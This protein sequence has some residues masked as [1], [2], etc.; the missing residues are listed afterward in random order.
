[1]SSKR[2]LF[3]N[4]FSNSRWW[5][6]ERPQ[7]RDVQLDSEG[8]FVDVLLNKRIGDP[9]RMDDKRTRN[10][11]VLVN[12]F[13]TRYEQQVWIMENLAEIARRLENKVGRDI[14]INSV[15]TDPGYDTVERL[16]AFAKKLQAPTGWTFVRATGGASQA[17]VGRMG[18]V[19]GYTSTQEIFY[20]TP[21]GFWGTFPAENTPAEVAYRLTNTIPRAKPKRLQRAGPVPLDKV[22]HNWTSRMS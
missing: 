10:K 8:E 16:Q 13:T 4:L 7:I 19:R 20:G 5:L 11:L 22:K 14:F 3:T 21:N 17:L 18:R 15:S 9:L 2:E 1:M 6:F 12:W